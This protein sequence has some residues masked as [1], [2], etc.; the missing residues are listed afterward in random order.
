MA[1]ICL[2]GDEVRTA[3]DDL[4]CLRIAMS[5]AEKPR[6]AQA[7]SVRWILALRVCVDGGS[8]NS[9]QISVKGD[10]ECVPTPRETEQFFANERRRKSS[11]FVQVF[12]GIVTRRR[13]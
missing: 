1:R 6:E 11:R 13:R 8:P 10:D 3:T 12:G 9:R 5:R 4:E 2:E 7:C